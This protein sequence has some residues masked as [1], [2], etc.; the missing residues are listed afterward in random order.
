MS[1]T[2]GGNK[3]EELVTLWMLIC[4]WIAA[5]FGM[6][7]LFSQRITD[8]IMAFMLIVMIFGILYLLEYR[9]YENDALEEKIES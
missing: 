2:G 8:W 5:S 9:D 6:I 1:K 7:P 3:K 4:G